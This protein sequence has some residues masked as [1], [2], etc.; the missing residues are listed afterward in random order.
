MG[1]S[2]ET[3]CTRGA[4]ALAKPVM[5]LGRDLGFLT[6]SEAVRQSRLKNSYGWDVI[7][8]LAIGEAR[9]GEKVGTDL[10]RR[11]VAGFISGGEPMSLRPARR[12]W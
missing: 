4:V 5:A 3:S 11:A 2:V 7:F 8:P 12:R 9:W 6:L 10:G 1:G